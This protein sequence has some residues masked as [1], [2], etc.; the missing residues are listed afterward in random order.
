MNRMENMQ[1]RLS[2]C[3][4]LYLCGCVFVSLLVQVFVSFIVIISFL[5]LTT[6]GTHSVN[7]WQHNLYICIAQTISEIDPNFR[8]FKM[9]VL[10]YPSAENGV[11]G[12]H[13][14]SFKN[15]LNNKNAHYIDV[16]ISGF[17]LF[18]YRIHEIYTK[19]NKMRRICKCSFF[20]KKNIHS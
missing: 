17:K 20:I 14:D 12:D 1:F 3:L 18:G 16:I 11:S 13:P 10:Y 15:L 19:I 7:G 2:V 6:F 9:A 5:K 8:L 4:F